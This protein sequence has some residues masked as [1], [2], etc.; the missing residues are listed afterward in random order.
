MGNTRNVPAIG[1]RSSV[2]TFQDGDNDGTYPKGLPPNT[3]LVQLIVCLV[4]MGYQVNHYVMRSE[5][6]GSCQRRPRIFLTIAAPGLSPIQK[7]TLTHGIPMSD[8]DND[9]Y[10]PTPFRQLTAYDG[11]GGLDGIHSGTVRAFI[12]FPDHRL[13]AGHKKEARED[14]AQVASVCST[15]PHERQGRRL[16]KHRLMPTLRTTNTVQN[17]T[18]T[19]SLHWDQHRP[20]T[21][22]EARRGQGWPDDEVVVGEPTKQFQIVGNRVDRSVSYPL[23]LSLCQS[24]MKDANN[25]QQDAQDLADASCSSGV[26][27]GETGSTIVPITTRNTSCRIGEL[28]TELVGNHIQDPVQKRAIAVRSSRRIGD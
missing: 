15:K 25:M 12:R 27:N 5:R 28:S 4:S 9:S 26:R 14:W 7:P 24:V 19:P 13:P 2:D 11:I 6:L 23:G 1:Q 17:E 8:Q 16:C 10:L 18:Y 21:V 22:Q 20:L 3:M